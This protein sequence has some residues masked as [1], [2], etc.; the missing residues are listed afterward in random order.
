MKASLLVAF[1]V[2]LAIRLFLILKRAVGSEEIWVWLLTKAN[3]KEIWYASLADTSPPF[4]YFFLRTISLIS[5]VSL[6]IFLLRLI[7]LFFG[8]LASM[9]IGYQGFHLLGKR[10]GKIAFFLSLFS[11]AVIL[12]SV[13]GRY[14]SFL[15]L[16]TTLAIIVFIHFLKGEKSRDLILLGGLS[17]IGVYTH[18]YFFLL[19]LSFG[20]YLVLS[21]KNRQ[22]IKNWFYLSLCVL[23]LF[24]PCL[25]YLLTLP[26]PQLVHVGRS[27]LKVPA[28]V[29][30]NL[31]SYETLL[32]IQ[33][34]PTTLPYFIF[35][36]LLLLIVLALLRE[37]L[38]GWKDDLWLLFLLIIFFP[39]IVIF[40]GSFLHEWA[41]SLNSLVVF[42]PAFLLVLAKGIDA[43]LQKRKTLSTVFSFLLFL[44]LIFF[45]QSSSWIADLVKPFEFVAREFRRDDIVLHSHLYTFLPAQYYFP[46]GVNFG[47]RESTHPAQI[48]KALGYEIVSPE[49][50]SQHQGRVWYFDPIYSQVGAAQKL[51]AKGE[52]IKAKLGS[53]FLLI[54]E[55][56][57][58]KNEI[59][60]CLYESR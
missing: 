29:I 15:I 40:L 32:Y 33:R 10:V 7:S 3:F 12:P 49:K 26:K 2:G 54:K 4:Y 23:I 24:L 9:A 22:F 25:F 31:S 34:Q 16:L 38:R 44:S 60:V 55:T 17:I 14:Y 6:S 36:S 18:Y 27:W 8:I 58:L 21:Q 46:E 56:K 45:F 13:F 11:P 50:L 57:F 39:P 30:V 53:N 59:N 1:L 41:L 52:E 47:V 48:E 5:G 42:L 51:M 20:L 19:L 35:L 28:A 43:D 37:S